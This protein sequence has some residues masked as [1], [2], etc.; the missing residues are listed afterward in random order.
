MDFYNGQA[1]LDLCE[2]ENILISAAMKEREVTMGTL[3][4]EEVDS[5]LVTVLEIMRNSS[6]RPIEKPGKSIGGLIG[7]EAKMVNEYGKTAQSI[8]GSMLSK[9]ISY[10][11][12]VLEVNASMGLIVAAPTAGSS[13]VV[14]GILMALQE[15][16]NLTDDDLYKGLLNASAIGY[17]LMRNASVSGAE[18]GCQAEVG[19]ASAMAASAIVEIMGGTP[20][21]CL[22]AAVLAMS[23]LLGLVCDPIAGLVE[24]PCQSRNAIGVANAITSAELAMAGV[25]HPIPFDEMAEAMYRVGK[26]LP[27]ELRET[28][29][30]GCAGTPTGCALGCAI[31]G[32]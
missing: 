24:S 23:N 5:K 30:G 1:L 18:A 3:T 13:G 17:I 15:E 25:T 6:H 26:S 20:K 7:G 29:M 4:G 31:C 19:A 14:P 12:A 16:K 10:S 22:T 32:K 11:M 9:A 21:Q 2:K 8:A 28:A 27:F